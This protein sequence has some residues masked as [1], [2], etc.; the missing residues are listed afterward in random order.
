AAAAKSCR[1]GGGD[2]AEAG[3]FSLGGS[4]AAEAPPAGPPHAAVG[5]QNDFATSRAGIAHRPADDEPSRR[6][7]VVL[8]ISVEQVG[9]NGGL[10]HV[11]DDIGAQSLVVHSFRVLGR[12]HHGFHALGLVVGTVFHCNLR[13][14]VRA[15]VGK[16]AVFANFRKPE[17]EF[18]G[19]I[20]SG[21]HVVVILVGGVTKHHALVAGAAGI[22]THGDVARLFVDAGNHRAGVGIKTVKR[23]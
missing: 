12:D 21:R 23:I 2:K 18:V 11:P 4:L 17:G 3:R 16:L 13:F 7:D 20:D 19:Q 15:K 6:V 14:S 22:Y 5:P 10:N 8:G 9:R 1:G